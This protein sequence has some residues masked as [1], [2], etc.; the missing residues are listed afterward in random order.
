MKSCE[1]SKLP[2]P[3]NEQDAASKLDQLLGLSRQDTKKSQPRTDSA[4]RKAGSALSRASE[5]ISGASG[6]KRYGSMAPTLS[7]DRS[8]NSANSS[9]VASTPRSQ[10]PLRLKQEFELTDPD[11]ITRLKPTIQDELGSTAPITQR[12]KS[13]TVN[14]FLQAIGVMR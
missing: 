6:G 14:K 4:A 8:S 7:K 10:Q 1:F 3:I 5:L 2:H 13:D 12:T 11:V 9:T